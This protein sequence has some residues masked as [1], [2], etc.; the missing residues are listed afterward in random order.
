MNNK[1][2]GI[3]PDKAKFDDLDEPKFKVGD[4]VTFKTDK[5]NDLKVGEILEISDGP[6][7]FGNFYIYDI[8]E[9]K[10]HNIIFG[11]H[12]DEIKKIETEKENKRFST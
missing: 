11:V 6:F 1:D 2:I 9:T 4:F 8:E 12:E 5:T 10:D 3:R 7:L